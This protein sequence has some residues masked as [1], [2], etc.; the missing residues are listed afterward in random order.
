MKSPLNTLAT[1]TIHALAALGLAGA[2]VSPALATNAERMTIEVTTADLNL[3]TVEGQKTLDRRVEKAARSVCR[4][5][6]LS[7]GSRV[8]SHEAQTCLAKARADAKRQVAALMANEQRG[9]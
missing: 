6:S 5:T 8:L 1:T 9:G 4:A 7:T 3:A 2:A